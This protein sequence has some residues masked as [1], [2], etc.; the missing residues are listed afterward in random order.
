MLLA[1]SGVSEDRV[2]V[3]GGLV[4]RPLGMVNYRLVTVSGSEGM[5]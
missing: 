4:P 3:P 1:L 5:I 2:E